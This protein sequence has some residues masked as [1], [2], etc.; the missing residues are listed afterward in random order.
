MCVATTGD[1]RNF[2]GQS[3]ASYERLLAVAVH[4]DHLKCTK[5]GPGQ[6]YEQKNLHTVS[7]ATVKTNKSGFADM[8]FNA[9][10]ILISVQA[11]IISCL[12]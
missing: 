12:Y 3:H 2:R 4:I 9:Q 1:V 7:A 11:R 8:I 6:P 10:I 5:Y